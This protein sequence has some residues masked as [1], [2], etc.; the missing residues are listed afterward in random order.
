MFKAIKE[1]SK[2]MEPRS[3]IAVFTDG[4]AD[5]TRLI[6]SVVEE[7]RAKQQKIV[8]IIP[9]SNTHSVGLA[10]VKPLIDKGGQL[11]QIPV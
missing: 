5:D 1:A 7:I 10:T 4:Q 2:L 8:L 9:E 11:I 6:D 3:T